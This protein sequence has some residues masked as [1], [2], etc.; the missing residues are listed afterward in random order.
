MYTVSYL[1]GPM[2]IRTEHARFR[3]EIP[4]LRTSDIVQPWGSVEATIF[5]SFPLTNS[6][7][8]F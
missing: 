2:S 6:P 8:P 4:E 3:W 5:A 7:G 1:P